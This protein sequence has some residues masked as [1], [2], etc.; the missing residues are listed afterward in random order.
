M[1][2]QNYFELVDELGQICRDCRTQKRNGPKDP[3]KHY[4]I[5]SIHGWKTM[6]LPYIDMY[7]TLNR[8]E[9]VR[10]STDY[11][12]RNSLSVPTLDDV[13]QLAGLFDSLSSITC[14]DELTRDGYNAVAAWVIPIIKV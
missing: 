7:F 8:E 2:K 5:Q 10:E 14:I 12:K 3:V 6:I 11:A 9:I 1:E 4:F 13:T